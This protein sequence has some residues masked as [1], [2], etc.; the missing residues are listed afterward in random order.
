MKDSDSVIR[1]IVSHLKH[2]H[3]GALRRILMMV[4]RERH[5]QMEQ[6]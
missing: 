1:E 4:E 6:L 5:K 3:P 2:L